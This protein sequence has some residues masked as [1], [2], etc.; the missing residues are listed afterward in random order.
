MSVTTA[1][2]ATPKDRARRR[3]AAAV[4]A[5]SLALLL[6][7]SRT[8]GNVRDEGYY[9]DAA[10][11]YAAWYVDLADN[12]VHGRPAPVEIDAPSRKTRAIIAA[13]STIVGK[14][15]AVSSSRRPSVAC[16]VR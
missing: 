4:F 16:R 1:T 15:K 3:I 7:G 11:Q 12:L 2:P 14:R 13:D 5:A 9:F 10:E 8:Q 6:A